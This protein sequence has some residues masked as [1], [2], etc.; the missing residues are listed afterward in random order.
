[1]IGHTTIY[2]LVYFLRAQEY[3]IHNQFNSKYKSVEIQLNNVVKQYATCPTG[4]VSQT[5][6]QVF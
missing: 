4:A 5:F 1:M 2:L 6:K 3:M